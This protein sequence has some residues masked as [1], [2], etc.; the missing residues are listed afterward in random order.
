MKMFTSKKHLFCCFLAFLILVSGCSIKKAPTPLTEQP[1]LAPYQPF[2]IVQI[3]L[4]TPPIYPERLFHAAANAIA[5]RI[6][7]AIT[8]N[9]GGWKSMSR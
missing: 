9:F 6:D 8:V 4:D 5:D 1:I 2:R 3:C 7:S